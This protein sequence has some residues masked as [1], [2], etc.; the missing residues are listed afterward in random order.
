MKI[1]A[2]VRKWTQ[3]TLRRS[4]GELIHP[5]VRS[6]PIDKASDTDVNA[7]VFLLCTVETPAGDAKKFPVSG[8]RQTDQRTAGIALTWVLP[9]LRISGAE[10]VACDLVVVPVLRITE[11]GTDYRYVDLI[12]HQLVTCTCTTHKCHISDTVVYGQ[13]GTNGAVP[14]TDKWC[15]SE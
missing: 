5:S 12:Q 1:T 2:L 15:K 14:P 8:M 9:A 7:G 11:V 6:N 3:C 13:F 4:P 10:H